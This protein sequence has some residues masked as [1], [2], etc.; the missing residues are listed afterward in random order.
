VWATPVNGGEAIPLGV[1]TYGGSRPDIGA[2]FESAGF[3]P[4]G[5]GL[6]VRNLAPG[7]YF[8]SATAFSTVA[9]SF[10]ASDVATVS[11][12]ESMV[13]QIDTP[14]P[15]AATHQAVTVQGWAIDRAA[16]SGTGI[17]RVTIRVVSVSSGADVFNGDAAFE[18]AMPVAAG[19]YGPQFQFSGFTATTP[20]LAAGAYSLEVKAR[21]SVAG[22]WMAFPARTFTVASR[23]EISISAPAANATTG[24]GI[25]VTGAAADLNAA[26]GTGVA[27]VNIYAQPAAGGA[28]TFLGT[29]TYGGDRPAMASAYGSRFGPSGFTLTT[30]L[31]SVGSWQIHTYGLSAVTNSF[32]MWTSVLV[33]AP[34]APAGG[35]EAPAEGRTGGLGVTVTGWAIDA[36]AASGTG[37]DVVDVYAQPIAGGAETHLGRASYGED[38]PAVASSYGAQFRA[39]GYRLT[40]VLPGLGAWHLRV[41]ARSVLTGGLDTRTVAVTA[42]ADP[43][44][45]LEAPIHGAVTGQPIVF[46]GWAV[47]LGAASGTGIDAVDIHA[48]NSAGTY[49]PLGRAATGARPDVAGAFGEQ[50]RQSGFGL[51]AGGLAPGEYTILAIAH[52]TVTH[53]WSQ[54]RTATITI[55]TPDVVRSIDTPG[56]NQTVSQPFGVT[57]WR[58]IARTRRSRGSASCTSGRSRTAARRRCSSVRPTRATRVRTSARTTGAGSPRAAGA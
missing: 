58:S 46:G 15:G 56:A 16:S 28:L 41:R 26:T 22:R 51:S 10:T 23:P 43:R 27:A 1:A 31:P 19:S 3:T 32:T 50:F 5:F 37:V 11:V 42:Q 39:S 44:M 6:T 35:I 40:T 14:S 8:I 34:S 24:L 49:F 36:A 25:T 54:S 12:A 52:S 20:A 38:R 45:V 9:N 30:T 7:P 29:A 53:T 2:Y 47:D 57:G 13:M 4:S 17:D 18:M 48:I 21:S 33:H 55:P